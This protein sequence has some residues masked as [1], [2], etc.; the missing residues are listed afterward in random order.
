[1]LLAAESA[2][3]ETCRVSFT[4]FVLAS[5]MILRSNQHY[6][7]EFKPALVK[8]P[9]QLLPTGGCH[10][11]VRGCIVCMRMVRVLVPAVLAG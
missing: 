6:L 4:K 3:G 10:C 11:F 5:V 9:L 1:M 8:E 7:H 2:L